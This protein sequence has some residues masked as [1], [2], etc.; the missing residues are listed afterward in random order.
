MDVAYSSESPT[1]PVRRPNACVNCGAFRMVNEQY[2]APTTHFG[3][4]RHF[5][6]QGVL[7][8]ACPPAPR[9]RTKGQN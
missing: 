1:K 6:D 5:I 9:Q 7:R 8:M 3:G 2:E 4:C